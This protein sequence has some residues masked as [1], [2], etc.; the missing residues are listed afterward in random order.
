MILWQQ[1]VTLTPSLLIH[2][3]DT[4]F[5]LVVSSFYILPI[6]CFSGSSQTQTVLVRSGIRTAALLMDT[7]FITQAPIHTSQHRTHQNTHNVAL[8]TTEWGVCV[9]TGGAKQQLMRFQQRLCHSV[10]HPASGD[11]SP[12]TPTPTNVQSLVLRRGKNKRRLMENGTGP[13][14]FSDHLVSVKSLQSQTYLML[15]MSC[16]W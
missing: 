4:W 9:C 6:F 13:F 7:A 11:Y 14:I 5:S 2:I 8:K 3:Q 10:Y 12:V 15:W 1:F 16:V